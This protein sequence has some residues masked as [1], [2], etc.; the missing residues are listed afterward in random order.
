MSHTLEILRSEI[1]KLEQQLASAEREL[2][3]L[4][5]GA[6]PIF[7]IGEDGK[8]KCISLTGDAVWDT[9][10]N[11][12]RTFAFIKGEEAEVA[13]LREELADAWQSSRTEQTARMA[14]ERAHEATKAAA[15]EAL[16]AREARI[17]TAEQRV[18][19]LSAALRDFDTLVGD[20]DP[21]DVLVHWRHDRTALSSAR[22]LL[23]RP[24]IT[25]TYEHWDDWRRDREH[26]LRDHP[27]P[28][29]PV[30]EIPPVTDRCPQCDKVFHRP[31]TCSSCGVESVPEPATPAECCGNSQ[32]ANPCKNCPLLATPAATAR[33]TTTDLLC[34]EGD[35]AKMTGRARPCPV[36]DVLFV[37]RPEFIAL[38]KALSMRR[39]ERC[40]LCG[41]SGVEPAGY[42]VCICVATPAA[43][44]AEP[45]VHKEGCS[46]GWESDACTC[47]AE[48]EQET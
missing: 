37:L 18:A 5:Y 39:E 9:A 47:G 12:R 44:G 7:V 46:L 30:L 22:A 29:T 15:S 10:E 20:L 23:E 16:D 14:S 24:S 32:R 2:R 27:E 43:T 28:A 6:E 19:E 8:T 45:I 13:R 36:H 42:T 35:C 40:G 25:W 3:R 31:F 33:P 21:P 1:A 11:R 26:W 48:K 17:R 34:Y 38:G 4:G 41:G